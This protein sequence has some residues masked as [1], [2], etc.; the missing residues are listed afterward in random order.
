MKKYASILT[1]A[2]RPTLYKLILLLIATAVVESALF[3][4]RLSEDALYSLESIMTHSHVALVSGISFLILCIILCTA[5]L[6]LSGSKVSYTLQRL[7]IKEE[8]TTVLWGLYN[9]LCLVLFW[10]AQLGI[11]LFLCHL[12]IQATDPIYINDQTVFL[13]FYRNNFLHAL[14]PLSE[15][16]LWYRNAALIISLGTAMTLFSYHQRRGEKGILIFILAAMTFWLFPSKTGAFDGHFVIIV[17]TFSATVYS[18]FSLL[19]RKK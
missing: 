8:T 11:S 16:T 4:N 17:L 1:L 5:N 15:K 10:A 19:G 13:A 6:E 7:S 9:M 2:S 14:L 18:Y 3:M 12:Y